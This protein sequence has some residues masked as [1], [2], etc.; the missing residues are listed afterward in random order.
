LLDFHF[1]HSGSVNKDYLVLFLINFLGA[2]LEFLIAFYLADSTSVEADSIH[3]F[4]HSFTF[5]MATSLEW[6]IEKWNLDEKVAYFLRQLLGMIFILLA[7]LAL[8]LVSY[9]AY[10]RLFKSISTVSPWMFI[11]GCIGLVTSSASLLLLQGSQMAHHIHTAVHSILNVDTLMDMR[12][13][14]AVIIGSLLQYFVVE[15][16]DSIL[17]LFFIAPDIAWRL[18]RILFKELFHKK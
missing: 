1:R 8:G 2:S 18:N 11:A 17:T 5:A 16:I 9:Q 7:F 4:S 6:M 15:H 10:S 12:T 13:S 14:L 3:A